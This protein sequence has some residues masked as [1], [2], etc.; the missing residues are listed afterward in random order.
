YPYLGPN[1]L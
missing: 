1:T